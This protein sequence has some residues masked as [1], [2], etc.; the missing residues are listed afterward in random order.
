M[1]CLKL[2]IKSIYIMS[3]G[4]LNV[5]NM[6]SHLAENDVATAAALDLISKA[7]SAGDDSSKKNLLIWAATEGNIKKLRDAIIDSAKSD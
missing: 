6:S 5:F 2:I 3:N 1:R 4:S 7:C